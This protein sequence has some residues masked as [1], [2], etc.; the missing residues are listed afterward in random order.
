MI[1]IQCVAHN[2]RHANPIMHFAEIFFQNEP[3]K[4]AASFLGDYYLT[5]DKATIDSEGNLWFVGRGDDV[6]T[7]AG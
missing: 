3:E 2:A 5:G 1:L 4:T 6:I 7:S